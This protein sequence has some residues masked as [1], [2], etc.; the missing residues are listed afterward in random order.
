MI[1]VEKSAQPSK[2]MLL[3][4]K[5]VKGLPDYIIFARGGSKTAAASKMKHFVMLV[6]GWKPLTINTK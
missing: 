5:P 3:H 6:Y 1:N 2:E 4:L